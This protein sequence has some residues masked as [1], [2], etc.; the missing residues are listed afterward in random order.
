MGAVPIAI[1]DVLS[2]LVIDEVVEAF[3]AVSE[4]IDFGMLQIYSGVENCDFDRCSWI[5]AG[6]MPCDEEIIDG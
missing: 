2:I 1:L 5:F 6:E 4:G 3:Y